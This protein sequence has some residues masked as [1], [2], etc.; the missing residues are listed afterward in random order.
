MKL[1]YT[2]RK[3][4]FFKEVKQKAKISRMVYSLI[5][6]HYMHS[7]NGLLG[8]SHI[9]LKAFD[10]SFSERESYRVSA[11]KAQSSYSIEMKCGYTNYTD[12]F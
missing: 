2:W 12:F 4:F 8:L 10:C 7:N 11:F 3:A 6:I 5:N 9:H 1:R